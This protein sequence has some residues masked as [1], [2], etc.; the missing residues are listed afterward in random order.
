MSTSCTVAR[1]G[2]LPDKLKGLTQR[3]NAQGLLGFD[4]FNACLVLMDLPRNNIQI[5]YWG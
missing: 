5:Y 1:F 3:A 2:N 4:L